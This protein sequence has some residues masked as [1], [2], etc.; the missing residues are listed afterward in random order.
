MDLQA[1]IKELQNRIAHIEAE[2][3]TERLLKALKPG[4]LAR[5][6]AIFGRR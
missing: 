6:A 2:I 3:E 4:L 5:L 1:I